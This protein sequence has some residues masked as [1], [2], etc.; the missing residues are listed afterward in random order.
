MKSI[1]VLQKVLG[2][3]LLAVFV[4]MNSLAGPRSYSQAKAIAEKQAAKLGIQIYEDNSPA[5]KAKSLGGGTSSQAA[6]YYVFTNGEDKGF[7]I[8]SGD[9]RLPEIVGYSDKGTY[10]EQE[11]LPSAYLFYLEE[12]KKMTDRL[13]AGEEATI[14][15][16]EELDAVKNAK[17]GNRQVVKPLLG[18]IVYNQNAPFN[19]M[20][21]FYATDKRSAT[22]CVA[23]AMAQIMSYYKYPSSLQADI[24]GYT[25]NKTGITVEGTQKGEKYDWDNMLSN[26]NNSYTEVEANAVAKLMY[27]CGTAIKTEYGSSSAADVTPQDWAKYF[28]YDKDLLAKVYRSHVTLDKWESLIENELLA[29]RPVLCSGGGHEFICDGVDANGL[30]HVNWGWGG[31][32]NGY[33]DISALNPQYEGSNSADEA[34]SHYSAIDIL[35]GIAPDNGKEDAPLYTRSY[36]HASV[37]KYEDITWDTQTR[38][39]CNEVFSGSRKIWFINYTYEYFKGYVALGVENEKGELVLI[40]KPQEL[41]IRERYDKGEYLAVRTF[42]FDYAFPVGITKVMPVFSYDCESWKKCDS[43]FLLTATDTNIATTEISDYITA[44]VTVEDRAVRNLPTQFN[45][46]IR[47][48]MPDEVFDIFSLYISDTRTKPNKR[49]S[50]YAFTIPAHGEITKSFFATPTSEKIYFWLNKLNYEVISGEFITTVEGETPVLTLTEASSNATPNLYETQN[51]YYYGNL[52]KLP[53]T[54]EDK[55]RFTYAIQNT[56]GKTCKTCI[57]NISG[58]SSGLS[59]IITR[60]LTID[61]G[62]TVKL[63]IEV[64]PEE[65]ESRFIDCRLKFANDGVDVSSNLEGQKINFVNDNRYYPL[66]VGTLW[67]YINDPNATQ[68]SLPS[69]NLAFV[70]GGKGE[71]CIS[72]AK[73]GRIMIYNLAAQ[74]V[75]AMDVVPDIVYSIPLPSGIYLID[76]KKVMVK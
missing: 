50:F 13:L 23:T 75:K 12:Y 59:K 55:A 22:G 57:V 33:F 67:L 36:S 66:S 20:C 17:A 74:L 21:P 42:S 61:K 4:C 76:G 73:A 71:I 35:I 51:S 65:L 52:V 56:G 47:N 54:T 26:Y 38:K 39:N 5:C 44:T 6:S 37:N 16:L 15:Y 2:I 46:T 69:Q 68:I 43:S 10:K 11:D 62:Q 31:R 34:T 60:T 72:Y 28:G 41:S 19:Q 70:K 24:E 25:N 8:V 27:H 64:S 29:R 49:S 1:G 7:V 18:S 53:S 48:D 45:V 40:S 30:Y 58:I 63:L 14:S 32:Y 9:D 3:M